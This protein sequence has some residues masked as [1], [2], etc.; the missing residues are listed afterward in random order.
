V[1]NSRCA[2]VA[3]PSPTDRDAAD[4]LSRDVTGEVLEAAAANRGNTKRGR[5]RSFEV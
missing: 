5:S 1:R 2:A 4:R 3:E